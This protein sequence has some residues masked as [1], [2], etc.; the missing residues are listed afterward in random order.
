[1]LCSPSRHR[2]WP[3]SRRHQSGTIGHEGHITR[4]GDGEVRVA[5]VEAAASLL[6]RVQRWSALKAWGMRIA[7]RSMKNAIVAVARK[8]AVILLRIPA[9]AI[10]CS[11][12]SRSGIPIDREQCGV[13]A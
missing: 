11:D 4:Q 8:L 9:I 12:A 2:G 3:A 7:K 13:G 6:I 10:T 5:L 1:M